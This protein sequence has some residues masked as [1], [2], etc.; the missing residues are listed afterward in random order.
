[1]VKAVNMDVSPNTLGNPPKKS[2]SETVIEF[3]SGDGSN[4]LFLAKRYPNI[5]FVGLELSNTSVELS[6]LAAKKFKINNVNFY[7]TDLTDKDS[8]INLLKKNCFVYSMHTLE[9]MPRIFKIPV[10]VLS[11]SVINFLFRVSRD[12]E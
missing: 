6:V 9:E 12:A 11:K 10:S 2:N 7:Q 8:Y 4:I 5:Q 1:M 3:G